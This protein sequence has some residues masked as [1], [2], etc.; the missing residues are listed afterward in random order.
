MRSIAIFV[1][2][3]V[4]TL[5]FVGV[6]DAL[7]RVPDVQVR[8]IGTEARIVDE[9]G[10]TFEAEP[11][12]SLEGLELLIVPGGHG[13]RPLE[14][15]ARC[16]AYLR[17]WGRQKPIAS[18]CTGALLLGRAGHLEGLR[19]TTH[20]GSFDRLAPFCAEVVRHERVV[21]AGRVVTAGA[22]ASSLD[23][24]LHLVKKHWGDEEAARIARAMH[25]RP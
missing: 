15:D 14:D 4:T 10:L 2:P 12:P 25:V 11:W 1:F 24:G 22:V 5:D 21:D 16:I 17:G 6:Y 18:V 13:S 8:F 20:F 3:R 19:A 9:G 23:L 7:R